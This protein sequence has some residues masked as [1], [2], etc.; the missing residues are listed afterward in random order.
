M[1]VQY[2]YISSFKL[3]IGIVITKSLKT[4][5]LQVQTKVIDTK[6]QCSSPVGGSVGYPESPNRQTHSVIL[7]VLYS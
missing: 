3:Q 6:V 5:L 4:Y 2:V 1:H 7:E